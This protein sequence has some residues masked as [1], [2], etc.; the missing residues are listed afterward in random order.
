M[1]SCENDIKTYN[2]INNINDISETLLI[3]LYARAI[4]SKSDNPIIFDQKAINITENLNKYFTNSKSKLHKKLKKG[5]L[6]KKIPESLS[7]R[8]R[9]FDQYVLDFIKF[10]KNPLIV[11]LGCGLSTRY[12]R[13]IKENIEW[14]D[15]DFPEVINIRKNFFQEKENY[16]FIS[17]S[18]LDFNWMDNISK[19]NRNYLFI[20]EGLF[21]YLYEEDVKKL[22]IQ[23]QNKFPGCHLVCEIANSYIIKT[24]GRKIWRK[25]F[26]R[27][28]NLKEN[29]VF[30]FGINDSIYFEKWNEGI[31]FLDEWTY[32][33]DEDNKLGWINLLGKIEKFRKTQWIVHYILN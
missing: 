11:E 14:Y 30:N 23:L 2:G 27:D 26:Q 21:M 8:T 17:S 31:K 3:P 22:V 6:K 7:L 25:K 29:A 24:L 32:F 20:A 10:K 33:D 5:K 16:H 18:V 28:F 13:I 19:N 4:E 15:L 9:K 1:I 12:N